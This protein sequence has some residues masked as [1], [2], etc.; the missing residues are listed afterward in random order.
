MYRIRRRVDKA[1]DL[2]G[3]LKFVLCLVHAFRAFEN[4]RHCGAEKEARE[5]REEG[6]TDRSEE[7]RERGA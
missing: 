3:K 6:G 5:R 2:Y 7:V 1:L 4:L